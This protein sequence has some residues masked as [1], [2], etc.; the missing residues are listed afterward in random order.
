MV[1]ESG[2][3]SGGSLLH[4]RRYA[5]FDSDGKLVNGKSDPAVHRLRTGF[6]AGFDT[7]RFTDER[8]VSPMYDLHT[9]RIRIDAYLSGYFGRNVTLL[10]DTSGKF[11]DDPLQSQVTIVSTASLETVAEHFDLPLEECRRRFRANIEIDGVPPFWEEQLV[12]PGKQPV[13]F[14][15]GEV[16]FIGVKP[17]P[18]CVVP[19]RNPYDGEPVRGFQKSLSELRKETLPQWSPLASYGNFYQLSVSCRTESPHGRIRS[20][21][22]LR[23]R[24]G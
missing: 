4:D 13:H 11:L 2:F 24:S 19:S 9:H 17:C 12:L 7:V 18:R 10:E 22:P 6:D 5:V 16:S 3:T 14:S 21:D 1:S 20:G 23:R 15:V 8:A